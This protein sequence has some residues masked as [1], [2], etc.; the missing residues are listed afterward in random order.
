MACFVCPSSFASQVMVLFSRYNQRR[1]FSLLLMITV[2]AMTLYFII[3]GFFLARA[4]AVLIE[5]AARTPA[6]T[7]FPYLVNHAKHTIVPDS[8]VS[9]LGVLLAHTRTER[10]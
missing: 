3:R 4:A 10:V 8:S 6:L 1:T 7:N 5:G 9:L 2:L